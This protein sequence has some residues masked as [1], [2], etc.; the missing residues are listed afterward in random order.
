MI[1]VKMSSD[2]KGV[3]DEMQLQQFK[4]RNSLPYYY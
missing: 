2:R 1:K 3:Y 4:V